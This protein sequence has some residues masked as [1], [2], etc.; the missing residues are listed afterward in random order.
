MPL[1][2]TEQKTFPHY[3]VI[4]VSTNATEI[5]LPSQCN[6]VQIG[7]PQKQLFVGQNGCTDGQEMPA[8]KR[9][10]VPAN[11]AYEAPIGRGQSRAKSI[12]VASS[13]GNATVYVALIE[14]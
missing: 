6:M 1:D 2:V 5:I 4:T 12:F 9:F 8:D 14:K 7:C 10:F 11:N 3:E 13:E